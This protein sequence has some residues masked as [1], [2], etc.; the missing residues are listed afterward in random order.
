[1]PSPCSLCSAEC[2]KTYTITVTAFDI[3]RIC[4]KT[5]NPSNEFAFLHEPRLLNY[6]PELVLDTED[7]YG[8]YL[9]GIRSHPCIF[10][11]KDNRCMI[12]EFAPLSCRRYPF[13]LSGSFNGRFCPA[14]PGLLLRL[15]GPDLPNESMAHELNMHKKIVGEWNRKPGKKDDCVAFLL[16][17]AKALS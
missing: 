8:R 7:G 5:G 13:T 6:D 1:M 4:E 9:L 2:C 15:K 14:F 12:H 3:L 11:G 17:K 10:I 16:E